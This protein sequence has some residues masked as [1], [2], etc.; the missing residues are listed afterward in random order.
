[1]KNKLFLSVIILFLYA[2]II[3]GLLTISI[4]WFINE[5][6]TSM[7]IFKKF[8]YIFIIDFVLYIGIQILHYLNGGNNGNTKNK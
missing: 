5:Y 8:W 4:Y 1:M 3:V 6:Y 7:Q 2:L